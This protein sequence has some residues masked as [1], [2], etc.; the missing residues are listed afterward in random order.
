LAAL[1]AQPRANSNQASATATRADTAAPIR[2]EFVAVT[3]SDELLEQIGQ[4]LDGESAIRHAETIAAAREYVQAAQPCVILLDAREHP[5]AGKALAELQSP[6]GLSVTVVF[7]PAEQTAA[8]AQAIKGSATFAVLPLPLETAKTAAV[9]EGAREEAIS[10]RNV[11]ASSLEAATSSAGPRHA[12]QTPATSHAT[13]GSHPAPRPEPVEEYLAPVRAK[14]PT[15]SGPPRPVILGA[16]A[17]LALLLIGVAW[18]IF[19]GK[20]T[21]PMPAVST[22]ADP[23]PAPIVDESAPAPAVE[24]AP[25]PPAPVVRSAP[26]SQAV[27]PGSVDELLDKARVAFRERRFTD[28]EKDNALLYYRSALA[29]EPDNGEAIEGLQRIGALLDSR[30]QA[31]MNERRL[32]EAAVAL[33]QLKLIKPDD[34]RLRA[35]EGKLAETR[36]AAALESKDVD[37]AA[38]LL[39]QA[40]QSGALPEDRAARLREDIER[41]Q[42][43]SREQRLS[44]LVAVRIREGKLVEPANDSAK[45]HL[46]QL[47]KMAGESRRA[48]AA[49][50]DLENAF[51]KAARDAGPKKPAEMGRWLDEARAMGASQAKIAAVQREIRAASAAKVPVASDTDRLATLVQERIKDGRLLDPAQDSALFHLNALR[52]A[53]PSGAAA[54]AGTSDLSEKLLERSRASLAA[55]K[56]DDAHRHVTAA[57]QLGL[58]M[59]AVEVLEVNIAA[60]R[61]PVPVQPVQVAADQLKRTRY[62]APEYPRAALAK[63]LR[64]V[65][66]VR[67]TIGTDGRVKDALVTSSEPA[68]VFDEVALA[69]VRRWRFKPHEVGGQP[70]E[71]TTATAMVFRPDDGSDP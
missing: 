65:V 2:V 64:G 69:A 11:V 47:Q 54:G 21:E 55:G 57:R 56:L 6:T 43:D 61:A 63:E 14:A 10:R 71:A 42:T 67:Y 48:A 22:E 66:R 8:V 23:V 28:P 9:L 27:V 41:R 53:D 32:D 36:I 20:D 33:A 62:A 17:G 16:V 40:S 38:G 15:R 39:R 24:A 25:M 7:A 60:A 5:D 52:A 31:A 50:R 34:A 59:P 29:Q 44:E 46:A 51:L 70:V 45:F 13:H 1:P 58:N 19:R 68:G 18:L 3:R 35:L 4:A 12:A 26:A 37:R 49:G 30:V